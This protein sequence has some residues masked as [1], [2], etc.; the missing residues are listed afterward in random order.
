MTS[1]INRYSAVR[2]VIVLLLVPGV[3]AL[4]ALG[5]PRRSSTCD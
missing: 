4:L 3:V 2:F 5:L 1:T